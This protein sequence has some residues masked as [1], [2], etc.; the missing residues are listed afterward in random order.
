MHDPKTIADAYIRVW[1]EADPAERR[2]QLARYWS[3]KA[4]YADPLMRAEGREAIAVMIE[5]ARAQFPGYGFTL[6]STPDGHDA[7]VRFSW[8]LAPAGEATL[9][10]GTDMVRL[11]GDG[12]IAEVIGFLDKVPAA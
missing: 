7:Y 5:D 12:R 10:E 9:I 4:R 3:A 8:G 11:D 1:N 2:A 6:G